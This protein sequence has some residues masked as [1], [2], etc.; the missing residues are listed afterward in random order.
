LKTGPRRPAL[1]RH[2][3]WPDILLPRSAKRTATGHIFAIRVR[4][5]AQARVTTFSPDRRHLR[6]PPSTTTRPTAFPAVG[7]RATP[8]G[9]SG[10]RGR[11][12][13]C[14]C[15]PGSPTPK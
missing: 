9:P 14:R 4:D 10:L 15:I 3:R 12:D 7:R 13:S 8:G 1:H 5:G 6:P 2:L 11:G